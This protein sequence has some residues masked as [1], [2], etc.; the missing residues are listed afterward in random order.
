LKNDFL[1]SQGFKN[2]IWSLFSSGSYPI[3]LLL[4]TPILLQKLGDNQYG[5]WVLINT[6]LQLMSSINFGL[7]D[8]NVKFISESQAH[9]D[10]Q[11]TAKIISL[12]LTISLIAAVTLSILAIFISYLVERF[13]RVDIS[14]SNSGYFFRCLRIAF[15]LFVF[16]FLEVTLLSIYQGFKR[17][18]VAAKW[19]VVSRIMILIAN[20][21]CVTLS[22]GLDIVLIWTLV[23][24]FVYIIVL[25]F[26]IK[27]SYQ[28]ISFRPRL[29]YREA[30]DFIAFGF[31]T[32]A[33]NMM[34]VFT[35][36]IDKLVVVSTAGLQTLT[37]YSLGSMLAMQ[38][39]SIFFSVSSW[40]FP[41][42]SEKTA[43]KEPLEGLYRDS[44]ALLQLFGLSSLVV[45]L[46]LE[47]QILTLWLGSAVYER[48]IEYIR[49]FI[50]Y[51]F[52]LLLMILPNFFLN[53][54]NNLKQNT[55]SEFV[56]KILNIL[57]MII[58]YYLFGTIGL[59]WGLVI[60]TAIV[61]P[62]KISQVER[63]VLFEESE[64]LNVKTI[65]CATMLILGLQTD[66]F[67]AKIV[68][69]LLFLAFF[70]DV[71][72]RKATLH[73]WPKMLYKLWK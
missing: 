15:F 37:Y 40:V 14:G 43:K 6:V 63:Y 20:I 22:F 18:D 1:R 31:W 60:S 64:F 45:F 53:G 17:Y 50:Y 49:V 32:W 19:S 57:F 5:A 65:L 66:Y 4:A 21:I 8:S 68:F 23:V 7:G 46:L 16:K 58:F 48:S 26:R 25:I 3:L 9:G 55:L 71:F 11:R 72:L 70:Y 35:T 62:F 38:F 73:T 42:V 56:L 44:Q 2:A 27:Q 34:A 47:K 67:L 28:F 12:S 52:F 54:S 29:L 33:Q 24:Q 13:G 61:V 51:N 30:R 39:H 41:I 69:C 10:N 36:Q 59:V